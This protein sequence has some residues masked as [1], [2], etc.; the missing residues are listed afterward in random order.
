MCVEYSSPAGIPPVT[1]RIKG[2]EPGLADLTKADRVLFCPLLLR[3]TGASRS[4]CPGVAW[5]R[6]DLVTGSSLLRS[7]ITNKVGYRTMGYAAA[8]TQHAHAFTS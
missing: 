7:F 1:R 3:K 6:I 8:E 2:K 5:T 4:R